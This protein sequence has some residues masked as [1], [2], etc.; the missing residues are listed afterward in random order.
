ML[1][2]TEW[3]ERS[4]RLSDD[5]SSSHE[6][7]TQVSLPV[8]QWLKIATA[9]QQMLGAQREPKLPQFVR[10][11]VRPGRRQDSILTPRRGPIAVH[12][13]PNG[14]LLRGFSCRSFKLRKF[15]RHRRIST[16]QLLDRHVLGLVVREA[17]VAVRTD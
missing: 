8:L 6:T 16:C 12:L 15:R 5:A 13:G 7:F 4:Y 3:I 2:L 10:T 14:H 17:K 11:P 1:H 9:L